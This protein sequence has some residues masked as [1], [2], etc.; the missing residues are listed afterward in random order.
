MVQCLL[1]IPGGFADAHGEVRLGGPLHEELL[2]RC[3][4]APGRFMSDG[5]SEFAAVTESLMR[6]YVSH[7]VVPPTAK[8]RME[9]GAA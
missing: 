6:A 5:G 3:L 9:D 4:W 2:D 1:P 8:R 7:Q